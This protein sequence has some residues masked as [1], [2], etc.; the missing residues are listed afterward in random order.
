MEDLLTSVLRGE[1]TDWPSARAEA[2]NDFL[3]AASRHRLE[4]LVA[5]QLQRSG[6]LARWPETVRTTLTRA[7]IMNGAVAEL[8]SAE[9]SRVLTALASHGIA[10]LLFKGAALAHTHY[11]HPY[12]RPH[13][14]TD[15]FV[16][17]DEAPAVGRVLEALGYRR[18]A[19]VS[20]G[21]VLHQAPY[22]RGDRHGV[23]HVVDV[24]WKIANPQLFADLL[25]YDELNAGAVRVPALGEHA[26]AVDDLAALVLACL[27]RV[28]HHNDSVD[29]LWLYDIHL[30]ATGMD[31]RRARALAKL[32]ADKRVGA[33]C[34][35]GLALAQQW[36][37]TRLPAG[38]LEQLQ[39]G[40]DEACAAYLGGHL[41]RLD[42]LLSDLKALPG[43]RGRWQL[44]REH[45]L[46]PASYMRAS[47]GI[48]NRALLPLL[49][50]HRVARGVRR[51]FQPVGDAHVAA[52]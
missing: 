13:L 28:V 24:H 50:V 42:I 38:L 33:V 47:Y 29:L 20:G 39:A 51:W 12:L 46:P 52:H 34:A 26:R 18:L 41:R 11:P 10:P 27:H 17:P 7:A 36:F 32:V 5:W 35:R 45:V 37:G 25:S 21:L 8:F 4:P 31:E 6:S 22:A 44:L 43:W 49:Y 2:E 14:D 3:E 23:Q 1:T 40:G 48:S 15:L 19:F 30:L 16:R 9:L